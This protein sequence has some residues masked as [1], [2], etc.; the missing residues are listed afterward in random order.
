MMSSSSFNC[1]LTIRGDPQKGSSRFFL[2]VIVV[3]TA[4]VVLLP[5]FF[6]PGLVNLYRLPK[7]CLLA[8]LSAVLCWLW[9]LD[10]R[11]PA[12]PLF[13]PILSCLVFSGLS[14]INAV[15]PYEGACHLLDLLIGISL[16]WVI[17][18]YLN[19]GSILSLFKWIVI[20]GAVVSL[21]GIIQT[22]GFDIPTLLQ[23]AAPSSTFGNKNHAAQY[24]LFVL[25]AAFYLL[26]SAPKSS[27]EWPYAFMAALVATYLVYTGTRAT[28]GAA[29]IAFITLCFILSRCG[30]SPRQILSFNRRKWCFLSGIIIFVTVMSILPRHITPNFRAAPVLDR[31]QSMVKLE[32]SRFGIWANTLAIFKDHPLLGVGRG[33][34]QFVYPL[35]NHRVV[36]DTVF[37]AKTR[38]A[39]AHNDYIQLLA[40]VGFLG[41]VAFF[42]VL[43]MLANKYRLAIRK[44]ID[45]LLLAVGFALTAILAEAFWDFPF[46]L[47][48]STAFFWIY[49]GMLWSLAGENSPESERPPMRRISGLGIITV[50]AIF[51]TAGLVLSFMHLGAEFFYSRVIYS[52]VL[53]QKTAEK[54][55]IAEKD[56]NRAIRLY[57]FDFKYYFSLSHLLLQRSRPREALQVNLRAL[58]LDP[59]HINLLNNQGV[60]YARL[61]DIHKARKVLETAIEIYPDYALARRNLAKLLKK[62]ESPVTEQLH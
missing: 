20:T 29:I 14:I 47:S 36:R 16:F 7:D 18:N 34:L 4:L 61:G 44:G 26:L 35:Y 31:L 11:R 50:L 2:A 27:W 15:N 38:V 43:T 62:T 54:L 23:I 39:E 40:E 22:W 46:E 60:I 10:N 42:W 55:D 28:W 12:F 37:N 58:S 52:K 32:T 48:V 33:N 17:T 53:T 3:I 13:V 21:I 45:P 49:A 19:R 59:H 9:L 1:G 30:F 57:P 5:L 6:F 25:P 51:I 56:L 41:T 8:I 24:I